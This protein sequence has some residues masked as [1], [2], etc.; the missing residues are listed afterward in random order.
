MFGKKRKQME[1]EIDFIKTRLQSGE[2]RYHDLLESHR[3]LARSLGMTKVINP[4][5]TTHENGENKS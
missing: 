2:D 1:F 3:R 5:P 4:Q